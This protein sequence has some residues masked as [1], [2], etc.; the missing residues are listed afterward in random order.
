VEERNYRNIPQLY[1]ISQDPMSLNYVLVFDDKYH[2]QKLCVKCQFLSNFFSWC[3]NCK[4]DHF[5]STYGKNPSENHEIDKILKN[6]YLTS[7]NF[8][9]L[10][11]WIPYNEFKQITFIHD[12]ESS[13]LYKAIRPRG[14]IHHLDYNKLDWIRIKDLN[15]SLKSFENLD[16]FINNVSFLFVF[17]SGF[18]FLIN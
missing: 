5:E 14:Y 11:E 12:E 15:V 2:S 10:I 4:L 3:E 6:N 1:G 16:Y 18:S 9:E 13:K 17:L 8:E 7:K